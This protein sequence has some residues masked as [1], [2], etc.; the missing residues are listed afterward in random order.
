[1]FPECGNQVDE[2]M[3]LLSDCE[4]HYVRCIKPNNLKASQCFE[5]AMVLTQLQYSGVLETIKIRRAG[6]AP[7]GHYWSLLVTIIHYYS[8][9]VTI[10]HY[11]S[12]LVTI[13]HYWSLLVTIGHHWSIL[14][15]TGHY[16]SLLVT[17]GHYW[18][19]LVTIGHYWS[20][21]VTIGHYW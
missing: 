19:L 13:G 10:G 2:L 14:V 4:L 9:L 3:K 12:L 7:I 16:W 21:L 8:L 17:I 5:G 1:M 15:T 6:Y 11:W 20:L 18:S